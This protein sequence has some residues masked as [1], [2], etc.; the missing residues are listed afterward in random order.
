MRDTR[1]L[2]IFCGGVAGCWTIPQAVYCVLRFDPWLA[3]GLF[4]NSAAPRLLAGCAILAVLA[5]LALLTCGLGLTEV[6]GWRWL[7]GWA[8]L[9]AIGFGYEVFAVF[10]LKIL[11]VHPY[12]PVHKPWILL[13]GA[14]GFVA[15]AGALVAALADSPGTVLATVRASLRGPVAWAGLAGAALAVLGA[16]VLAGPWLRAGLARPGASVPVDASTVVAVAFSP[17][18]GRL[19]VADDDGSV[20]IQP[21]DPGT[22]APTGVPPYTIANDDMTPF[23]LAFSPGGA[24]VVALGGVTPDGDGEV[25]LWNTATRRHVLSL[26]DPVPQAPVRA[27]AF[28]ADG[29]VL[30]AADD[31]GVTSLW[32]ART[33]R[34]LARLGTAQPVA[35]GDVD[36]TGIDA[37]AFSPDGSLL[38]TVTNAGGATLWR[39]ATGQEVGS[40]LVSSAIGTG[41]TWAGGTAA[42][43]FSDSDEYRITIAVG[44]R[45]VYLW[46][47]GTG[48]LRTLVTWS[49]CPSCADPV[50]LSVDGNY[51]L[52]GGAT[53]RLWDLPYSAVAQAWA[54][55]AGYR[56]ESVALSPAGPVAFGDTNSGPGGNGTFPAA[57]YLRY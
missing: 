40:A 56:I 5:P 49:T 11:G 1:K 29:A 27:L 30:A 47:A 53:A 31:S 20:T 35:S 7:A 14:A 46:D 19:A 17:D 25:E 13:G 6:R 41:G 42:I 16:A 28:A 54:D 32:D 18:G 4:S 10:D 3:P 33:G 52:V 24:A 8:L 12:D 21:V 2:R 23:A 39:T 36:T 37:V 45:G 55:P 48:G 34:L 15:V 9:L 50:A 22:G 44:H 57:V 38:A 26:A 43:A 51:A